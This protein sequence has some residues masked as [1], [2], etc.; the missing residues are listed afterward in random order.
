MS[1]REC[2]LK[3][4]TAVTFMALLACSSPAEANIHG[5]LYE[6]VSSGLNDPQ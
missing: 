4:L 5:K 3:T 6:S 1:W 2:T